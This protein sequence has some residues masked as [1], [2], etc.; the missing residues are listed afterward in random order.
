MTKQ[1]GRNV[2]AVVAGGLLVTLLWAMGLS[3]VYLALIC[4]GMAVSYHRHRRDDGDP[5]TLSREEHP[6]PTP[7]DVHS[8]RSW[9]K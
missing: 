1:T 4:I 8:R 5:P 2:P 7:P 9:R 6:V 3:Y